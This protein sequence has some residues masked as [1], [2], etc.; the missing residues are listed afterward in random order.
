MLSNSDPKNIYPDDNFF[1]E[2]YHEYHI[3][4]V[5]ARRMI[6]SD[7]NKRGALNEIVVT[8]YTI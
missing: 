8:N 3:T 2:I 1:D 5:A 4:R 6:N 7:P